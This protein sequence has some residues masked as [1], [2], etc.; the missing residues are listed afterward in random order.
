M[1]M[2]VSPDGISKANCKGHTLAGSGKCG[3]RLQVVALG[4]N[5]AFDVETKEVRARLAEQKPAAY[6]RKV[7]GRGWLAQS[8]PRPARVQKEQ[9]ASRRTFC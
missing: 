8:P 2:S 5:P 9:F 3:S 6:W 7:A 4:E 1:C